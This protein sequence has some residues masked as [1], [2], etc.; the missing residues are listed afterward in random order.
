MNRAQKWAQI[1][2]VNP[3]AI[4]LLHLLPQGKGSSVHHWPSSAPQSS[5]LGDQ[6]KSV[7]KYNKCLEAIC[8]VMLVRQQIRGFHHAELKKKKKAKI[9]S[10]SIHWASLRTQVPCEILALAALPYKSNAMFLTVLSSLHQ[11]SVSNSSESWT[12]VSVTRC[13]CCLYFPVGILNSDYWR[14]LHPDQKKIMFSYSL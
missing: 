11:V 13:Y 9:V 1:R 8:H 2:N 5:G 4:C 10:Q 12:L 14:L 3:K 7:K 6:C